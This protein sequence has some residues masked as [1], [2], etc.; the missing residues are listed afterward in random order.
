MIDEDI[1]LVG[2]GW[3]ELGMKFLWNVTS[4]AVGVLLSALVFTDL[5]QW[6]VTPLGFPEIT[7]WQA[8]GL[9]LMISW[10]THTTRPDPRSWSTIFWMSNAVKLMVW[11]LSYGYA[12]FGGLL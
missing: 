5:W 1:E 12:H 2:D 3:G 9:T 11:G 8:A 7:L 6:F 4:Y 10:L